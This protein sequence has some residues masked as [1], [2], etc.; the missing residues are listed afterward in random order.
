VKE[1][2]VIKTGGLMDIKSFV[3]KKAKEAKEGARSIA[4]VSSEQK[5][6]VLIKMAEAL[7]KNAKELQGGNRKDIAAAQKKGLSKAM[8]D[9]L[10]LTPQ[11]IEDMAKGLL[12]IAGLP[13]PVGEISKMWKRPNGMMVGRMRV[14]IGV[15]GI[16]Y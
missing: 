15:I 4:K 10:T 3:L 14:P 8:I 5:N 13:D 7:R 6:A 12:E 11:R 2:A 9:R 1:T 16:I